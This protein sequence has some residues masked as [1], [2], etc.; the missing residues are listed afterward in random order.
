[1]IKTSLAMV[2]WNITLILFD[3]LIGL[4]LKDL[5][6]GLRQGHRGAVGQKKTTPPSNRANEQA[7]QGAALYL[8]LLCIV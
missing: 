4:P 7:N 2:V 8:I 1:M 6:G 5:K 3:F